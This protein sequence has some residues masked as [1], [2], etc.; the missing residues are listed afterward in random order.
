MNEDKWIILIKNTVFLSPEVVEGFF[1]YYGDAIVMPLT[2]RG[3]GVDYEVS[4]NNGSPVHNNGKWYSVWGMRPSRDVFSVALGLKRQDLERDSERPIKCMN[5]RMIEGNWRVHHIYEC[6]LLRSP[7]QEKADR[8]TNLANL[9]LI[10]K[11]FHEK[12]KCFVHGNGLG[13]DWLKWAICE[14][15]PKSSIKL[16][17]AIQKPIGSPDLKNINIACGNIE[18]YE[19]LKELRNNRPAGSVSATKKLVKAMNT[20]NLAEEFKIINNSEKNTIKVIAK[21]IP[22]TILISSE[23]VASLPNLADMRT[24]TSLISP[25]EFE[26][27]TTYPSDLQRVYLE[28]R[29]IVCEFSPNVVTY[30]TRKNLVFKVRKMFAEIQFQR[31][32]ACLRVLIRPEGFNIPEN[33]HVQIY[34]ITVTRV[35]D[36]HLWTVNHK[37][38]IDGNSPMDDVKKLLKQSYNAVIVAA[39][40]PQMLRR[41]NK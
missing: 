5:G 23:D 39:R 2:F 6:G 40:Q 14:L 33:T 31:K 1:N 26:L 12:E 17:S 16:G 32:K 24:S 8:F 27:I 28:M 15:Y 21:D 25:K 37:F 22:S 20:K 10:N 41:T 38:E 3:R 34:G 19:K 7:I 13:A 35:P 36:T 4:H 29:K 30:A 9:V 11:E 18:S